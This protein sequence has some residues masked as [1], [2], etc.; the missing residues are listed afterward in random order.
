MLNA[1]LFQTEPAGGERGR[2][3][4]ERARPRDDAGPAA[5]GAAAGASPGERQ[6]AETE[7]DRS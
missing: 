1:N 6:P 3:E 4:R 5:R 2:Q 7:V